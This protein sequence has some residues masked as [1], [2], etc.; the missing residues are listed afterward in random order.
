MVQ[1][2][3]REIGVPLGRRLISCDLISIDHLISSNATKIPK[4]KD[5]GSK[6]NDHLHLSLISNS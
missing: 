3:S 5:R 2:Q 1:L 6:S 4:T